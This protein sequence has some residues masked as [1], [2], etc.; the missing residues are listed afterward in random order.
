MLGVA[1]AAACLVGGCE[2][3]WTGQMVRSGAV[4]PYTRMLVPP[5]GTLAPGQPRILDVYDAEE[6]LVNP[7]PA[8]PEVVAR[9]QD[10]FQIYCAVCHG[11]TGRSATDTVGDNFRSVPDLSSEKIQAYADGVIYS[12]IREGGFNM[13]AYAE[14]LGYEER[15]AVVRFVRSLAR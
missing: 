7:L 8:S 2:L 13:P 6:Q 12:A 3:P 11:P 14:S 10:L 1:L 4:Q 9:G 5:D 15:W